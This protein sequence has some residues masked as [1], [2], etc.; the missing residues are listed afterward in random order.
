MAQE[1]HFTLEEANQQLPWLEAQLQLITSLNKELSGFQEEMRSMLQKGR[2]N[3]HS[4]VE[5]QAVAKGREIDSL[6]DRLARLSQEVADRGIILRDP[7]RG[8][9]DFPTVRD[10]QEVYLCWLPG[11]DRIGFW[12]GVDSGFAGRQPL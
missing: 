5:Q 3:G 4:G 2:S 12:H 7:A 9:V 10:E 6:T 1:R 8:L 11:E